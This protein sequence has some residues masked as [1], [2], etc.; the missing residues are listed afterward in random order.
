MVIDIWRFKVLS[1]KL[2]NKNYDYILSDR[3]FYDSIVNIY[4]LSK[5]K[6]IIPCERFIKK[7]NTALYLKT[8]PE[9]IMQRERKPE[10]GLQYLKDKNKL[11]N[12]IAERLD[13]KIINGNRE[14]DIIFE[15]IKRNI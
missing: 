13:L 5:S 8:D 2:L 9:I 7:P 15:E 11:Y 12:E 1:N 6:K 10:Q 4:Y 14:K 3:Y